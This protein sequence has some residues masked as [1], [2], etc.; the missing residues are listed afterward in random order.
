[1]NT[2]TNTIEV[3]NEVYTVTSCRINRASGYGQYNVNV[4]LL[5]SDNNKSVLKFHSTDSQL[6]DAAHGED[7]HDEIVFE[8]MKWQITNAIENYAHLV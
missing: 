1:M 6:F 4:D 2:Q 5:D 3:N 8:S 7:N